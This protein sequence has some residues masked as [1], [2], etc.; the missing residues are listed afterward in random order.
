MAYKKFQIA[1]T[2]RLIIL[3]VAITTTI[4]VINATAQHQ[5]TY[6]I[7]LSILLIVITSISVYNLFSF[8]GKRYR[9]VDNFF[10][11]VQYQDFSRRFN[12]NS[13][14][15]DIRELRKKFNEVNKTVN[16]INKTSETQHLYL[17]KILELIKTGIIAYNIDTGKI[18]WCNE[19]FRKTLHI[20]TI[21]NIQF[22]EKRN[23]ALFD[24]VFTQNHALGNS[25]SISVNREKTKLLINSSDFE[26]DNQSYK[27]V[28]LQ[29]IDDTLNRNE[30]EAW[31]KLLSVMTH[32]IMN[33]IAPISSLAETL[34][35]KI[36]LSLENPDEDQ[37]D[38]DDVHS[39]IKIIKK[40][41]EGLLQFAKTYRSLNKVSTIDTSLIAIGAIFENIQ[42]LMRPLLANKNIA[43]MFEEKHTELK[44]NVDTSLIEQVLI[45]LILNAMDACKSVEEPTIILKA[46]TTIDGKILIKIIDN[47]KGIPEDVIDDI[48]IPFFTTKK[49]GSG[50]GLSLCKQIMLMHRGRISVKSIEK[51][52][53]AFSLIFD[54]TN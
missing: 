24:S 36:A 42:T 26:I 27:L 15:K 51:Q 4:V 11:T 20:P 53:T 9:E 49:T 16:Q 34:E 48:F 35:T 54:S 52:G 37:F 31:K 23:Q 47:G 5:A 41:S 28:V 17:N 30:S 43:L 14:S 38:I 45:N 32:E 7:A 25:I 13:G 44:I 18:I 29:N 21:K 19:A 22:I 10:E 3:L 46:E 8:I 40:R 6:G 1:L 33:S 39:G 50:I 2:I 12:E